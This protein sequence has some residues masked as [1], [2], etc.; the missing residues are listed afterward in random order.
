MFPFSVCVF[1]LVPFPFE[2]RELQPGEFW[3]VVAVTAV[4]QNQRE[5]YA[6]QIAEKVHRKE[7]PLGIQYKVFSDPPGSKIGE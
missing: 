2:G 3:D 7:L 5:A 4:D 6:L 1:F